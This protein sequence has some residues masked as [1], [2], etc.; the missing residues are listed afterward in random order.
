MGISMMKANFCSKVSP[1]M[2][3]SGATI[4][5]LMLKAER[6]WKSAL[7][8]GAQSAAVSEKIA[9]TWKKSMPIAMTAAAA[10]GE[11]ERRASG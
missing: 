6:M 10:N 8:G 11:R 7:T 2:M 5:T 1:G 3:Q 4:S 9:S